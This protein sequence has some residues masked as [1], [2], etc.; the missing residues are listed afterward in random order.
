[1]I[2]VAVT[3]L[4]IVHLISCFWFLMASFSDNNPYTWVGNYEIDDEPAIYQYVT[5]VYWAYQTLTTVGCG[6]IRAFNT[7][8]R[9]FS[10]L[11]MIFAVGFYSYIIGNLESIINMNEQKNQELQAKLNTLTDFASRN[12]LPE[13]LINKIKRFLENNNGNSSS[14]LMLGGSFSQMTSEEQRQLLNELPL[15][16]RAEVVKQTYRYILDVI[17]FFD[18]KDPEFLWAILPTFKPMQVYSKDVLYN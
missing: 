17:K 16:L 3:M 6:D 1:M 7:L 4:F 12:K 13:W 8:E 9:C 5:S 2:T 14:K 15:S 10:L 11:W 18:D